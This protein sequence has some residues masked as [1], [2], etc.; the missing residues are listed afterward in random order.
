MTFLD[1]SGGSGES[2]D[3]R[4]LLVVAALP[5]IVG[6]HLSWMRDHPHTKMMRLNYFMLAAGVLYAGATVQEL[7]KHSYL[8][9]VVYAAYSISA[10]A[11]AL[12]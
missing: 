3:T 2:H 7:L 11:L 9:A 6:R 5:D 12:V 1:G 8:M 10:F 4:N